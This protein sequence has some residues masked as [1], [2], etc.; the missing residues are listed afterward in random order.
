M[1]KQLTIGLA[2]AA[3]VPLLYVTAYL[4]NVITVTEFMSVTRGP[5]YKVTEYRIGGRFAEM[6]FGPANALDRRIRSKYWIVDRSAWDPTEPGY[7]PRKP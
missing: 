4:S 2:I 1:G 5:L 7:H 3:L 6:V